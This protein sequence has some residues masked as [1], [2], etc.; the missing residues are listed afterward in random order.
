MAK[1]SLTSDQ[2]RTMTNARLTDEL[3]C[4]VMGWKPGRDRFIKS[5]RQWV[6]RWRFQPL[7]SVENA[8]EL[9]NTAAAS[10]VLTTARDGSFTAQVKLGQRKGRA[11]SPSVATS[12]TVAIARA[13]GLDVP[14]EAVSSLAAKPLRRRK[15]GLHR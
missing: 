8:F 7:T 1:S 10:L 3:A 12:I 14:D 15:E 9:L 5:D 13:L 2:R 4:R 6:L 11:S